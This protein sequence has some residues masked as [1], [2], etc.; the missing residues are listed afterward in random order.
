MKKFYLLV[1]SF[2]AVSLTFGQLPDTINESFE[3]VN[4]V[5]FVPEGWISVDDGDT[6]PW[7]QLSD[8]KA[9]TGTSYVGTGGYYGTGISNDWLIT[10]HLKVTEG[11]VLTFWYRA[12]GASWPDT[13]R[14]AIS[15]SGT[16][17]PDFN[18]ILDTL[19]TNSE[20]YVQ[21]TYV[22]TSHDSI[23]AGDEVYIG[24]NYI[25][26][27]WY[28]CIDDFSYGPP[29]PLETLDE[30]FEVVD[31]VT[32]VPEGWI[33]VDDGD[34]Y[35]WR[36]LSD[37]KARTGEGYLGTGPYY[38]AGGGITNDWLITPR[39]TVIEGNVLSF[40][41]RAAGATWPDSITVNVSSTGTAE[42]DF[43]IT[44]NTIGAF[45][46]DYVKYTCVLSDH[47]ELSQGD[48]IY[49]G[50]NYVGSGWYIC[51][52]DFRLGAPEGPDPTDATLSD[53]TLDNVTIRGFDPGVLEYYVD[54]PFETENIPAAGATTTNPN[55]VAN[56]TNTDVLPGSTSIVVISEDESDTVTFVIH[57]SLFVPVF[58]EGFETG[59]ADVLPENWT[60]ID[61][62]AD[63]NTWYRSV[64]EAL[65]DSSA[66]LCYSYTSQPSDDWL[67]SPAVRVRQGARLS[68]YSR[69]GGS[70]WPEYMVVKASKTDNE[71]ANFTIVID[72]IKALA[73][74]E[75]IRF[76]YILTDHENLASGDQIYLAFQRYTTWGY[77]ILLDDILVSVPLEKSA[78]LAELKINDVPVVGFSP[79]I[80]EYTVKVDAVPIITATATNP[81]L[82]PEITNSPVVPGYATVMVTSL[83]GLVTEIYTIELTTSSGIR[84]EEKVQDI[85]IYPQPASDFAYITHI[86]LGDVHLYDLTGKLVK[87]IRDI[88]D[89][90]YKMDL[91]GLQQGVYFVRIVSGDET[92]TQKLSVIR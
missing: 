65:T 8:G 40:W 54:L 60:I 5:T 16:A 25:G 6:Y 78:T 17:D 76:E 46:E 4:G 48:H 22:L 62:D 10:P 70:T 24:L 86:N 35:P 52:D 31:P 44:L 69:V 15:K 51:I 66:A 55:S 57:F 64:G 59:V 61:G 87:V 92:I 29:P 18:I 75:Y 2:L 85:L 72:T 53:L 88:N 79:D 68:F 11:S 7:H 41:Y 49:I 63:E 12:G 77:Y 36:R 91:T 3:V 89:S 58:S 42:G 74:I 43:T 37:G 33:S 50:L 13:I 67:I 47:P 38:P 1:C 23:N 73:D 56:I 9:R 26:S 81:A 82:T 20:E 30:S 80:H 27:G 14:V 19:G 84:P 28:I 45:S 83:D 39:L 21:Y 90:T 71:I 34:G 32:Y